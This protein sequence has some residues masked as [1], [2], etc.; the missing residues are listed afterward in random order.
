[1]NSR[2]KAG[3]G[4]T[5][6]ETMIFLAVSGLMFIL[7][8]N[9]MSGKQQQTEFQTG[10]DTLRSSLN[11]Q[12]ANVSNGNF[13][14]LDNVI[15]TA[16]A[17]GGQPNVTL[18]GSGGSSDGSCDVIG[19]VIAF[20]GGGSGSTLASTYTVYPVFGRTYQA[21][22]TTLATD[23]NDADP[24][25]ATVAGVNPTAKMPFGLSV[26]DFSSATQYS[27]SP[28][29]NGALGL[30]NFTSFAGTGGE[31]DAN[32]NLNSGAQHVEIFA[33][34][35]SVYNR[36]ATITVSGLS[37]TICGSGLVCFSSATSNV[38]NP[39]SGITFCVASGSTSN[40]SAL[41]TVGGSYSPSN[42]TYKI[43]STG[44]CT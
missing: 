43:Y 34:P 3:A 10:V 6:V 30:F 37:D 35:G 36:P 32:G 44:N 12:L 7:A 20:D 18:V 31:Y 8:I 41:F 19:E 5:I 17:V 28:S 1:M 25:L 29:K 42:T 38:I 16:L 14:A 11:Q 24:I 15:C 21:S 39:P 40:E 23:I 4:F 2:S 9:A 27:I 26:V 33:L 13:S 22:S